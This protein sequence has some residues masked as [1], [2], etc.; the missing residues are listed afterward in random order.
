MEIQLQNQHISDMSD[1][2]M[3]VPTTQAQHIQ[4]NPRHLEIKTRSV[5]KTLEPLVMQVWSLKFHSANFVQSRLSFFKAFIKFE[6][7]VLISG[8]FLTNVRQT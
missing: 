3:G 7:V 8:L 5:E 6:P 2:G 4:W 1:G